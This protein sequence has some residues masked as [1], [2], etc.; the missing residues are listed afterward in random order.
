MRNAVW[1]LGSSRKGHAMHREE[2]GKLL[3]MIQHLSMVERQAKERAAERDTGKVL[4]ERCQ[5]L[6]AKASCDIVNRIFMECDGL[7]LNDEPSS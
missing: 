2:A 6:R 4:F 3:K 1:L 5:K 7:K